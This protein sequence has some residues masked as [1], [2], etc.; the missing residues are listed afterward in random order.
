MRKLLK[1]AKGSE[2]LRSLIEVEGSFKLFVNLFVS[3]FQNARSRQTKKLSFCRWERWRL[4]RPRRIDMLENCE[5]ISMSRNFK[6]VG[7]SV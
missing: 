4:I 2:A 7:L 6:T 5:R 1:P 3:K